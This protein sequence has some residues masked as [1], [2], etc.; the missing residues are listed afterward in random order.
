MIKTGG[1]VV[2]TKGD[3]HFIYRGNN[4]LEDTK[5]HRTDIQKVLPVKSHVST[6]ELKYR[7]KAE[8]FSNDNSEA[9]DTFFKNDQSICVPKDEEPVKGT[10]YEREVNRLLDSL[11]P[12]FV[13]WW[14][15]TPLPVDADVLPE[16]VPGY[17]TPFRQCPPGVRPTLADEE[18]TYLRKIARPLPTHFALG[19]NTKLQGL[20]AAIL[21]L[22]EKSLI[23]K[24]A[25]KVGIQNTDNEQMAWN[26]KRLAGGTVILRNKDFII[27]Y[28]GK[29]FLPGG[30]AQT[31]IEREAQ[32][33]DEQEREEEARL[34]VVDSL[35]MVGV[36]S[37]E[38]SSV[39]TFREYQDF[40]ANHVHENTENYKTM[41]E[42]E[43]EK[44]RLEKE[45]KDQEWK[46]CTLN[47][48][49]ERSNQVL[50]KLHSS[51]IPSE[52]SA[53]TELLTEEEK[54]IFRKIGLKMDE[55]VLLGRRG[56]FDGVIEEIH[57]HCKHKEVV[58]VITKQNQASQ[59]TYTAKLLEVETGGILIAIEKLTTSHAIY[60]FTVERI[61]TAQKNHHT[62][63]S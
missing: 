60:Y 25:V 54:V 34:K 62:E 10:L 50:A 27:L 59:I 18:L 53:D 63:I 35:Q 29:D 41:I 33:H 51:W 56:I 11:G 52:Q 30:V 1:L 7:S 2:W 31:V 15:N 16:Y 24:I 5:H 40:Q 9:D 47:K 17:K 57:Q 44:H 28:R 49:I 12:R 46:L 4:Y 23:A 38:E 58:K 6:S 55:H 43:A 8:L 61:T 14:W 32:V 36:L 20:A 3:I 45:L 48:K 21:K 13:D 37:P 22:W 42:L 19:R 26:L 39:G